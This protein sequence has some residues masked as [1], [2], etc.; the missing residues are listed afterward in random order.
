MEKEYLIK[1]IIED[2][3][4]ITTEHLEEE[5]ISKG[6]EVIRGN[7]FKRGGPILLTSH[8]DTYN[9]VLFGEAKQE[10]IYPLEIIYNEKFITQKYW[11]DIVN[12]ILFTGKLISFAD[13]KDI[14]YIYHHL[15]QETDISF[16][17]FKPDILFGKF[18][19]FS[20]ANIYRVKDLDKIDKLEEYTESLIE[21]ES[22]YS[23]WQEYLT[24]EFGF[25]TVLGADDRLGVALC[26]ILYENASDIFSVLISNNEEIGYNT[27]GY[28]EDNFYIKN[29]I[30]FVIALDK[31]EQ[32]YATNKQFNNKSVEAII[33]EKGWKKKNEPDRSS[34]IDYFNIPGINLGIGSFNEHTQAESIDLEITLK[35]IDLVYEIAKTLL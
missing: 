19:R 4:N 31:R 28:L 15:K 13:L 20:D 5:L 26:D 35:A 32:L 9:D 17:I 14:K 27:L 23:N 18:G 10:K 6:Y 25:S 33:N 2:Y 12:S 34:N 21:G 7:L 22:I 29:N 8:I 3:L 1:T 24:K 30:K 11:Y 16:F